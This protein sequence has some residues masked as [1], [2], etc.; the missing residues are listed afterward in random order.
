MKNVT[1]QDSSLSAVKIDEKEMK[2]RKI[3]IGSFALTAAHAWKD[4]NAS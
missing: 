2:K 4:E 3:I 1:Q